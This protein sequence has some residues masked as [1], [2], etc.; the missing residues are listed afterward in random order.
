MRNAP[1]AEPEFRPGSACPIRGAVQVLDPQDSV[2]ATATFNEGE[3]RIDYPGFPG[4]EPRV[5][6]QC[7]G[8]FSEEFEL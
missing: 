8:L 4:R 1:G 5:L 6:G 7:T 2:L 3:T